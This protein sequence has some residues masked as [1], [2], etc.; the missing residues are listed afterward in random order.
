[1]ISLN[2]DNNPLC[3]IHVL[4]IRSFNRSTCNYSLR[5][6]GEGGRGEKNKKERERE[7]EREGKRKVHSLY[8]ILGLSTGC[9]VVIESL[10]L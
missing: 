9:G 3:F 8:V 6:G 2:T 1:M 4:N 5:E 10:S 7:K